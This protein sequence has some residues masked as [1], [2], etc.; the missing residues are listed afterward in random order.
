MCIDVGTDHK[1]DDIEKR[2]PGVFGQELLSKRQRQG[3]RDPADLHHGPE[4]YFDCSSQLVVCP[5]AGDEG[6]GGKV[7]HVLDRGYLK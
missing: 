6:H 4:T 5:C 2:Y 1:G 7:D 3:R